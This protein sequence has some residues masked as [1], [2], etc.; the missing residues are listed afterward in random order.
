MKKP[1]V[2]SAKNIA[3]I[4]MMAATI[5]AAKCALSFLPNIELVSFLIILYTLFFGNL[6]FPAIPVFILLEGLLYGFGLWWIMYLYAWPLLA[7]LTL[8][9]RRQT[10]PLFWS[11]LSGL[12]GL[13]FG[14][15]CA[16]PYL[17]ISGPRGAFAWWVAG[18]PFDILHCIS[19]FFIC[20]VLYT[21]MRKLLEKLRSANL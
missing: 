11:V 3:L 4:G 9:F 8:L 14:A 21:P 20:L 10:S 12:F 18:I 6:I 19:N 15:L 17:F 5:E 7:L 2:L 1:R 16:I 13:F